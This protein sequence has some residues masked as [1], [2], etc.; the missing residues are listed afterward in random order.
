MKPIHKVL[1]PVDFSGRSQDAARYAHA[2]ASR[3]DA[4]LELLYVLEPNLSAWGSVEFGAPQL[5]EIMEARHATAGRDLAQML[6]GEPGNVTR[7]IEKGEAAA[8]IVERARETGADA[9]V[10]ATHGIGKF[11]RFILGSVT[12]K[13]LHDA[14][15]PVITGVHIAE[16][17]TGGFR[18]ERILCAVDLK[19]DSERVLGWAARLT[20]ETG[21]R[22]SALYVQPALEMYLGESYDPRWHGELTAFGKKRIGEMQSAVGVEAEILIESSNDI[23]GCVAAKAEDSGADLVVIG[24]GETDGLLGGLRTQSYAIIRRSPCPVLSV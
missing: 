2:L 13:V 5:E 21:A 14:E 19:P 4:E 9:I 16:P 20:K 11:R 3:F 22:L 8:R 7:V 18:M 23:A 6:A 17:E 12:A 10:I 15:C 24:R 1:C